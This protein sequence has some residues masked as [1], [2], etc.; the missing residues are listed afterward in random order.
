MVETFMIISVVICTFNRASYLELA[1]ESLLHQTVSLDY[2]EILVVDNASTDETASLVNKYR[3]HGVAYLFEPQLG[4]SRA[5]NTGWKHAKGAWVA[6][7][8]DDAIASRWWVEK[9]L[10]FLSLETKNV[11]A[12]AGPI[13]LIWSAERPCWMCDQL[14]SFL[15]FLDHGNVTR[16]LCSQEA[17]VGANS[18][19]NRKYLER[20]NGFSLEFGRVGKTL[21]SNEEVLLREA[22]EKL[23]GN[24]FYVADALVWHHVQLE[25]T[26]MPWFFRRFFWQGI[27]RARIEFGFSSS[28]I[29]KGQHLLLTAF[30]CTKWFYVSIVKLLRGDRKILGFCHICYLLGRIRELLFLLVVN[31]N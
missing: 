19:F 22:I 14:Q 1:I 5:R 23:G 18:V 28:K 20:A 4:L 12:I 27:T 6:Y 7:L 13:G 3:D 16:V 17:I 8:D 9:I 24:I 26:K 10:N 29:I 15:G 21:L 25:R 11:A 31:R 2:Y 30:S